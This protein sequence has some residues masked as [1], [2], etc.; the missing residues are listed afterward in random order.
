MEADLRCLIVQDEVDGVAFITVGDLSSLVSIVADDVNGTGSMVAED[1][2]GTEIIAS[3][4]VAVSGLTEVDADKSAELLCQTCR[5]QSNIKHVIIGEDAEVKG[6]VI[7]KSS[8]QKGMLLEIK[9]DIKSLNAKY[10]KLIEAIKFYGDKVSDF[11]AT[12]T[13]LEPNLKEIDQLKKGKSEL[14]ER[15]PQLCSRVEDNE[16]YFHLLIWSSVEIAHSVRCPVEPS[17]VQAILCVAVH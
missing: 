16:Q 9:E 3:D 15:V 11:E 14:K 4:D 8:P 6:S 13:K 7:D 10:D 1:V 5:R 2:D 17:E 12:I